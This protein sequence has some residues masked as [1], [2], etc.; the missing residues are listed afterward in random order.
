MCLDTYFSEGLQ[1]LGCGNVRVPIQALCD[2]VLLDTIRP[3]RAR[4]R[5]ADP[6]CRLDIMVS[7]MLEHA[8]I[9]WD[10][11]TSHYV[12][13]VHIKGVKMR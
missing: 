5:A 3:N 4:L 1:I 6:R 11:D 10:N 12:F 2:D 9:P 7:A 13:S 8:R